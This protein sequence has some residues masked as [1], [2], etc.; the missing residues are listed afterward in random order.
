MSRDHQSQPDLALTREEAAR[1]ISEDR[2]PTDVLAGPLADYS[3]ADARATTQPAASSSTTG[4]MPTCSAASRTELI[5]YHTSEACAELALALHHAS[6]LPFAIL[7]DNEAREDWGRGPEPTPV[8]VFILD[9]ATGEAIDAK[10]RRTLAGLSA[11]YADV[12]DAEIDTDTSGAEVTAL[13][14]P[15]GP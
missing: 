4:A 2:V 11:D 12:R 14:G 8:H 3:D 10:G 9:P 13:M 5:D 1:I 6:G 15:N 7:W